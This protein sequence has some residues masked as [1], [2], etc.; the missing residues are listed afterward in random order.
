M[1]KW[2]LITLGSIMVIGLII[3]LQSMDTETKINQYIKD[4]YNKEITLV[5][6]EAGHA[7][8]G[9]DVT[10]MVAFKDQPKFVFGVH[11]DGGLFTNEFKVVGD[12][13]ELG[14][15]AFHQYKKL[16]SYLPEFG[17]VGFTK[18]DK[19]NLVSYSVIKDQTEFTLNMKSKKKIEDF[20][21]EEEWID[22]YYQLLELAQKTP[23]DLERISI[24]VPTNHEEGYL[25]FYELNP[26]NKEEFA[27]HFK[28]S[29]SDYFDYFLDLSYQELFQSLEKPYFH[30]AGNPH[31]PFSDTLGVQCDA[32][33]RNNRCDDL[34]FYMEYRP[35]K[36]EMELKSFDDYNELMSNPDDQ[37]PDLA[38]LIDE[39]QVVLK[40][41]RENTKGKVSLRVDAWKL[42]SF[43]FDE[44]VPASEKGI[45]KAIEEDE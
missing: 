3:S 24:D 10:H 45:K 42:G 28:E 43:S 4:K 41:L 2:I 39:I 5:K 44:N 34:T 29:E 21:S 31:G 36:E 1:N 38:P 23:L 30:F 16:E 15:A 18:S 12:E 19:R 27:Q 33:D 8:N 7:G 25:S 17:K 37:E 40:E 26:K 9:G 13:L 6:E 22:Q 20:K 32:Y 14:K 35:V 11:V